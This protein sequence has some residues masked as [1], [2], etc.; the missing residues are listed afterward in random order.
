MIVINN[1]DGKKFSYNGVNYYKNFTPIVVGSDKIRIL[2]TYDSKIELTEF[3]TLFSE[4]TLDGV[5]YASPQLLQNALLPVV[6]TRSTL[7]GGEN[8]TIYYNS[9]QITLENTP[10]SPPILLD[11]HTIP[12]N[13]IQN[14]D[15]LEVK[16]VIAPFNSGINTAFGFNGT[17]FGQPK[18]SNATQY[19]IIRR[20]L[21]LQD[22]IFYG[23]SGSTPIETVNQGAFNLPFNPAIDNTFEVYSWSTQA[24]YKNI[25][26]C[27]LL[28]KQN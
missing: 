21:M 1:I 7:S 2:N 16:I 4:I 28:E 13:T 6:F 14:G 24:T 17:L 23:Q 18:T 3:P 5:V 9:N 26:R 19:E 22:G 8:K 10:S 11:S 27:I 25:I 20:H 12:A 15:L